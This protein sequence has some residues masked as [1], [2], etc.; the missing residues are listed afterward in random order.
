MD[1]LDRPIEQ[2]F[3]LS[4]KREDDKR[5]PLSGNR[6][7]IAFKLSSYGFY[8]VVAVLSV[9]TFLFVSGLFPWIGYARVDERTSFATRVSAGNLDLGL[10]TML[11]FEGQTAFYEY[12]ST[13]PESDITFDVKP[14]TT[15]GYSDAMQRVKGKSSGRIEFP[16]TQTGLYQFDQEPALGRGFVH[17]AYTVKWGAR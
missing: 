2:R 5:E 10:K 9:W 13:S 3:D 8:G 6:K 17:T 7:R 1:T 12:R 16:I 11:L 15:L 14:I 4:G